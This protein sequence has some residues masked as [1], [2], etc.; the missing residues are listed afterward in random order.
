MLKNV[1]KICYFD[2]TDGLTLGRLSS[3]GYSVVLISVWHFELPRYRTSIKRTVGQSQIKVCNPLQDRGII[4]VSR[5]RANATTH[6]HTQASAASGWQKI[7]RHFALCQQ[8]EEGPLAKRS[9]R[10][11]PAARRSGTRRIIPGLIWQAPSFEC[12]A[13][14]VEPRPSSSGTIITEGFVASRVYR[15]FS[16]DFLVFTGSTAEQRDTRARPLGA[17]LG[18]VVSR[19]LVAFAPF[20]FP[21]RCERRR[22]TPSHRRYALDILYNAVQAFF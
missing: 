18:R 21:L 19:A 3:I 13:R 2:A 9:P 11:V 1:H 7:I 8:R 14:S 12:T 4:E 20:Y 15:R 10:A 5:M 16:L 17:E 22:S 6:T